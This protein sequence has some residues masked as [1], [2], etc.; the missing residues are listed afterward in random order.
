MDVY[1]FFCDRRKKTRKRLHNLSSGF[2]ERY[3]TIQIG[4]GRRLA[5]AAALD[6][7]RAICNL[8]RRCNGRNVLG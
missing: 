8:F 4:I 5:V 6:N 7:N 3:S 1:T 2:E